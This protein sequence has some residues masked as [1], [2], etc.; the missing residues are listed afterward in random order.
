M[1]QEPTSLEAAEA[2]AADLMA[3]GSAADGH[4]KLDVEFNVLMPT[5]LTTKVFETT[6]AKTIRSNSTFTDSQV[7]CFAEKQNEQNGKSISCPRPTWKTRSDDSDWS[8]S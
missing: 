8:S 1:R 7:R 2:M 6:Q 5:V 4:V 3:A